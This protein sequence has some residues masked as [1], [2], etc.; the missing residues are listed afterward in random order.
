MAGPCEEMFEGC[1]NFYKKMFGFAWKRGAVLGIT[2][3]SGEF[4]VFPSWSSGVWNSVCISASASLGLFSVNI[5]DGEIRF[6]TDQY[7]GDH[8][9][10]GEGPPADC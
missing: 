1:T 10:H 5:N 6:N 7:D 4:H 8:V 9:N 2:Y 3:L